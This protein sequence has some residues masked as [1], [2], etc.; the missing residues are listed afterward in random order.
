[1]E[2]T[3]GSST[4]W[5][6]IWKKYST[7]GGEMRKLFTKGSPKTIYQF[8]QRCYFEDFMRLI[9]PQVD[10]KFLELASVRGTTSMYLASHGMH[11][12]TLLDL[13]ET[14]LKQAELNFNAEGLPTPKTV[15]G[16]AEQTEFPDNEFDCIY[17]IGVLE[18][19]EDPT[20]IVAESYRILKPGGRI[21][22]PIV[23]QMPFSNSLICRAMLNPISILR[24]VARRLFA[25]SDRNS[26]N[27]V[28]T[29]TGA[30]EYIHFA[31]K[32]GFEDV[33][34]IPYNAYWKVNRDNSWVAA[35]GLAFFRIHHRLKQ[36]FGT[37]PSLKT[38]KSTSLCLLLTARK[39]NAIR[40]EA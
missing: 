6:A 15:V 35:L 22:M 39:K 31:R 10:W 7:E 14:A 21:F 30:E 2:N 20:K 4:E 12:I 16:D 37:S 40:A 29:K 9:E 33:E 11:S 24:R 18:H 27:M 26:G 17:N 28:R 13:S 25:K 8:W 5:D 34:C 19:F 36:L 38:L 3:A 1:M 23:P 32:A